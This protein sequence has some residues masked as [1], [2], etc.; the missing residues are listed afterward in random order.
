MAAGAGSPF[1]DV[2]P[3]EWLAQNRSAFALPDLE[4]VTVGHTLV[5]PRRVIG[6]WWDLSS[7]EQVDLLALVAEV[8]AHLDTAWQP[9]GFTVGF[10]TGSAADQ[11]VDQFHVH[12]IPR[13][14]GDIA[15]PSTGT[16]RMLLG[17]PDAVT[18]S[19]HPGLV[20][21]PDQVL[22][23]ELI[24]CLSD[25]AFDRIDFVV[26]FVLRSG[27]ALIAGELDDAIDRG[28]S[29]RVLTT[30]YMGITEPSA[31]GW[32]LDRT[33]ADGALRSGQLRARVFSDPMLS[34]HPKAY[35]FWS[36]QN[37]GGVGFVGSSNVSRS[38][39]S[40]GIE[41]NVRTDAM[42]LLRSGFDQLWDDPRS[43]PL[44]T[45][46]LD[47]YHPQRHQKVP[48][49]SVSPSSD[50]AKSGSQGPGH[51]ATLP[52]QALDVAAP[53]FDRPQP[54]TIQ[55]EGLLALEATRADGFGAGL[56]VMATGLGKTWLAAFDSTRPAFLRVLFV[57]H[58]EEILRQARDVFR[59]VRPTASAGLFLGSEKDPDAD[60]VF[61][62]VQTMV[63][64]LERFDRDAFDYVVVDEFHH[65]SASSYRKVLDH[66]RPAFTLGLTATP[67]R[68]DGADLLALCHDNQ[69]FEC[70]LVEG[71]D[72]LELV[73]FEYWGVPDVVDFEPIPWR[74]GRF[75]PEEL[76]A[77]VA[78]A[79][80]AAH[81]IAE[82]EVRRGT[83]TLAFC[84]SVRHAEF[85]AEE[86]RA[87]GY[88]AVAVHSQPTSAPRHASI[89]DLEGGDLDVVCSVDM[90]N[91]GLDVPSVDTVLMLRP[92]ESPVVFL[93]QLGRGLRVAQHKTHLRVIDFIGNHRSFLMRPRTLLSLG[94]R[95]TPTN[96]AALEAM[97]SGEFALPAGCSVHYDLEAVEL[98]QRLRGPARHGDALVEFC[99]S[100]AEEEG[101]RPTAAQAWRSGL[102]PGSATSR[103]GWYRFLSEE[104]L[105]SPDDARV[106]ASYGAFLDAMERAPIAKSYKLVT[107]R[108]LL[109][110]GALST[111]LVLD[112]L[113]D[114]AHR[115][116][117]MD[118]RLLEDTTSKELPDP[119]QAS[120]DQFRRYWRKWPVAAWLGEL[121][122]KVEPWFRLDDS[123]FGL[124]FPVEAADADALA[125]MLAEIVEYRLARYLE[126]KDQGAQATAGEA[127]CRVSHAG[128]RPLVWL[129][130]RN[131]PSLPTGTVPFRAEGQWYE[132][133]FRK[134]A[135][136]VAR[137]PG[138]D[139][140]ALH[141]LLRGWF[142]PSAGHPGTSHRVVF[143]LQ[144]DGLSMRPHASA[145]GAE[146]EAA[147][148]LFPTLAVACGA[149]EDPSRTV[150]DA[151]TFHLLD[152]AAG[153]SS[154]TD[155]FV[156]FARGDSMAGGHD[157]VRHGDPLLFQWVRGL[158]RTDLVGER[159]LVQYRTD[160]GTAT[161][162]KRL[163]L[164]DGRFVLTSD[165]PSFAPIAGDGGMQIVARLQ[166]RL[167][168]S[169]INPLNAHL[170]NPYV[171]RRISE[172]HGDPE[173]RTN[174]QM[175]HVSLPGQA[176]LLVTIDKAA[177]TG[178]HY[179]D[180]FLDPSTMVW[181][182]QASTGPTNKKG[183][184]VLG[185]LETGT[186]LHLWVRR[187]KADTSF[188]YCGLVVPRGHEGEK[189]MSV[190]FR[191]LTP[192]EPDI[193][194]RLGAIEGDV[195]TQ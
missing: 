157:P 120:P 175:G 131:H 57:A 101:V 46:W 58:R 39:L 64:N 124:T 167:D 52:E 13:H 5:I 111:G 97:A 184:E 195:T 183:R 103:D 110:E 77:A 49:G 84:A 187:R 100:Y 164:K 15:S 72:R 2:P 10:D 130:R 127:I 62:S 171:R 86:F 41:W 20:A 146:G 151:S 109:H 161:A 170:G 174:W 85:M 56:V 163:Q 48:S 47:G 14:R 123:R 194:R 147:V 55:E 40:S 148:P 160:E 162:L 138:V 116:I 69:P 96:S 80:R 145:S 149:F 150:H 53:D 141:A 125:A 88:R 193:A 191:L 6:S 186:Q 105:L 132:G 43:V 135:L 67:H 117:A 50:E 159:V 121:P 140:N 181:S 24:E 70:G 152:A 1:Y 106:L 118:P 92:T 189:P 156:A 165:N 59:R 176:I 87:S 42:P 22:H 32:L 144:A 78:T 104:Q 102:N 99:H 154:A 19:A 28:A 133:D 83:R 23:P 180:H 25:R 134:E 177:M 89:A 33:S 114:A 12:V 94:M 178:V 158:D 9:I 73:P 179:V 143:D 51:E 34:F 36:S 93:Q 66:F 3:S 113:A 74:N 166:R 82:W 35:L 81:A 136:N 128:G 75:D 107:L 126:G 188:I 54:T 173:Q 4:P 129:D 122:G 98:L 71:I 155:N 60:I 190:T 38:G 192:L 17:R 153:E 79:E 91:E 169:A 90:F 26:S 119:A 63:R 31:L 139:G 76:T 137:L 65:A 27:L 185:A 30:D 21:G 16:R 95:G 68:M 182:S 29:V 142:G 61:A 45:G 18:G 44:T 168:Q 37:Q 115:I 112:D 8:K 7:E 108:A 11:S 172:L